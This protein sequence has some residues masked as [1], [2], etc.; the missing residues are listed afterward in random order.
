MDNEIVLQFGRPAFPIEPFSE[1]KPESLQEQRDGQRYLHLREVFADTVC[2]SIGKRQESILIV[3]VSLY[4]QLAGTLEWR[5]GTSL[6]QHP[7]PG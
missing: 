1:V 6:R 7:S 4:P 2:R 3:V 5:D